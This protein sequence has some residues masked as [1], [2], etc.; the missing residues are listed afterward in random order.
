VPA[1]SPS[2]TPPPPKTTVCFKSKYS[3]QNS[4]DDAGLADLAAIPDMAAMG[5]AKITW[6]KLTKQFWVETTMSNYPAGAGCT[7]SDVLDATSA[8]ADAAKSGSCQSAIIASHLHYYLPEPE[9]LGRRRLHDHFLPSGPGAVV[10]CMG[11]PLPSYATLP[12]TTPQFGPCNP[13]MEHWNNGG[14]YN[15]TVNGATGGED[16][17]YAKF[18][19]MLQ[20]CEDGTAYYAGN[21]A[22]AVYYNIHSTYSYNKTSGKGLARGSLEKT[23]CDSEYGLILPGELGLTWD[24]KI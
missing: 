11:P 20:A 8:S 4:V 24:G 7:L 14:L 22:C 15:P 17:S 19:K 6:N 3:T 10:F 1:P 2:P 5:E 23:D 16:F 9:A 18:A 12:P 13:A 21:T